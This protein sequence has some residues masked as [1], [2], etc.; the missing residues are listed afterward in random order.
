M[1]GKARTILLVD[2]NPTIALHYA[3]KLRDNGLLTITAHNG[4]DA[5][6]CALSPDDPVDLVL[7]DIDLKAEIDGADAARRILAEKTLPIIF[8]SSHSEKDIVNRTAGIPTFGYVMKDS[9]F[10]VLLASI[11]M[12]FLL[13]DAQKKSL[14]NE[15]R[16]R[17]LFEQSRDALFL[18]DPH[19]GRIVDVNKSGEELLG[20]THQEICGMHQTELHPADVKQEAEQ[21]FSETTRGETFLVTT[22]VLHKSGKRIPVEISSSLILDESGKEF[23]LG[24]F[25]DITEKTQTTEALRKSE[26]LFSA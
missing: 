18:A 12:A 15:K 2:D 14:A 11:Q 21:G 10:S 23:F 26:D 5:I 13:S 9:D 8:L 24:L 20:R 22:T 25:R 1:E 19:T 16:Y 7:M 17:A 4:E 3:E 6:T